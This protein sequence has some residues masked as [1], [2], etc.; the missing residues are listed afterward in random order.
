LRPIRFHAQNLNDKA[1]GLQGSMLRHGRCWWKNHGLE[2]VFGWRPF[3]AEIGL[4]THDHALSAS[5]SLFFFTLYWNW[6]HHRFH[7]WLRDKIRRT[8][9]RYGS[10]R[11]IG[12]RFDEEYI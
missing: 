12:I 11:E 8:D 6:D 7:V 9:E 5:I 3:A 1:G 2:W 4:A 10:G